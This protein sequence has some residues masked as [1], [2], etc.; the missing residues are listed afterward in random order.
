[1]HKVQCANE[2]CAAVAT[3]TSPGTDVHDALD[4]A[5]CT[6]CPQAHNHGVAARETGTPCRP[7][8]I[9]LN[10]GSAEAF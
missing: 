7:V 1:M 10:A 4:A 3:V 6:C 2:N 8:T 9:I 5:G